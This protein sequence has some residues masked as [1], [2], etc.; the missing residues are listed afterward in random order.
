MGFELKQRRWGPFKQTW[1]SLCSK[2]L[3]HKDDCNLC[4][5]G[6]WQYNWVRAIDHVV[7]VWVYP[8]WYWWHN[9][10][11]SRANRFLRKHFPNMR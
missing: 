4:Q 3:Y 7:Y 10:R 8:V 6:Q 5:A 9:R 11:N 2:H 1:F